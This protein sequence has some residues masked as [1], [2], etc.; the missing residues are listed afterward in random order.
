MAGLPP[1]QGP[2]RRAMGTANGLRRSPRWSRSEGDA[3][4]DGGE[5]DSGDGRAPA[6][7]GLPE[8]DEAEG[9]QCLDIRVDIL[10]VAADELGKLG[11]RV[12]STLADHA[13]QLESL[14]RE[15]FSGSLQAREVS[16][17]SW[18]DFLPRCHGL[19]G[20]AKSFKPPQGS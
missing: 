10:E 7:L 16:S 18:G 4:L 5:W 12:R 19:P 13:E 3:E 15:N 14:G 8:R 20:G 2:D 11:D 6:S 1:H 17:L 9:S